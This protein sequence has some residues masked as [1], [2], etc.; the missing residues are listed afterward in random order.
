M[1]PTSR[2][3]WSPRNLLL[4]FTSVFVGGIGYWYDERELRIDTTPSG[5]IVDLFY[6]RANFQ[7]LYEQSETPV[8]VILPPRVE[9]LE[10]DALRIRVLAPGYQQQSLTIKVHAR[11]EEIILDLEPLANRLETVAHRYFAGRG[12]LA[13]MTQELLQPRLQQE[14]EGF[15][16][17]LAE[18]GMSEQAASTLSS[19]ENALVEESFGQQLGEDLAVRV[20][21]REEHAAGIELRSRQSYDAA[22][23][24]HVFAIDLVPTDGGAAAV[25]GAL[26]ALTRLEAS[27][28]SKCA[29]RFD[30]ALRSQ[31]DAG[32]L[33]RAIE[34]RGEFTD[35]YVRAAMRRMGELAPGGNVDFLDGS[36]YRPSVPIELDAALSQ[37]GSAVGFLAFLRSF[38][39]HF[40]G[41]HAAE[42]LRSLVAPE[43]DVAGFR[44]QLEVARAAER[45]CRAL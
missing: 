30:E 22:R 7:K 42:A 12:S 11:V 17:F 36:R 5:A 37:A 16:V 33:S 35:R 40:E 2:A 28:L 34:P 1:Q 23:E 27:D 14:T 20:T 29:L 9:S 13:L 39:E 25:A 24:L 43:Q 3:D 15:A 21:V 31:L 6:I 19:I 32:A 38:T 8:T 10:R 18:S 41:E 45:S 44:E 26:E 4:P